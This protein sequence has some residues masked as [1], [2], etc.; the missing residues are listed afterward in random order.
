MGKSTIATSASS[1]L[2]M[3][4]EMNATDGVGRDEEQQ[5]LPAELRVLSWNVD[6]LD[7]V[8]LE[9]RFGAVLGVINRSTTLLRPHRILLTIAQH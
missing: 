4:S 7:A 1:P 9:M 5:A 2:Q 6:G 8:A 3:T